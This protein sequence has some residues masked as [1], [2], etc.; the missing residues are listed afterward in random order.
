MIEV[1]VTRRFRMSGSGGLLALLL[2]LPATA[3]HSPAAF[4]PSMPVSV[5]GV[6]TA[7]EWASPHARL[8][9]DAPGADGKNVTWDF[10]L[11]SPVTLMRR[12]W[13]RTSLKPGDKVAV[14]GIRAREFPLIAIARGV[15]DSSGKRLFSG[16]ASSTE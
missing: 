11:P 1:R 5:S 3:H 4:D 14:T 2:A 6:V 12:G 16:T 9:V 7:I 15:T 10:E 13:S 8:K